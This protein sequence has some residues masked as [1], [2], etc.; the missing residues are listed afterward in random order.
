MTRPQARHWLSMNNI[1]ITL[2]TISWLMAT[3]GEHHVM[4]Q[5]AVGRSLV[6]SLMNND[7][8]AYHPLLPRDTFASVDLKHQK[9]PRANFL[10]V[11]AE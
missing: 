10:Y 4:A 5:S 8:R 7:F 2:A 11:C 6:S 1:S 3:F 9:W